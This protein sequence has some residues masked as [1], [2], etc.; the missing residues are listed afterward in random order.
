MAIVTPADEAVARAATQ[1]LAVAGSDQLVT[2]S[3]IVRWRLAGVFDLDE[4][5]RRGR[6][7][8]RTYPENAG[9]I[10]AH[11]A[12]ALAEDR[13]LDQAMLSSFAN[14]VQIARPG[15]LVAYEHL[16]RWMSIQLEKSQTKRVKVKVPGAAGDATGARANQ[17]FHAMRNVLSGGELTAQGAST[18]VSHLAGPE[19]EEYLV[20][21]DGDTS[22]LMEL[23]KSLSLSALRQAVKKATQSDLAWAVSSMDSMVEYIVTL[24]EFFD[25]TSSDGAQPIAVVLANLGRTARKSKLSR[26]VASAVA[27]PALLLAA[28]T[29]SGRRQFD[30]GLA[31]CK[32]ELPR[33]KAI[34]A[35]ARD[36][37]PDVRKYLGITG[38]AAFEVQSE[39]VRERLK[40]LVSAWLDGHPDEKAVL[41]PRQE[42]EGMGE[43][44][45]PQTEAESD[46]LDTAVEEKIVDSP[47]EAERLARSRS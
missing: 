25:L 13:N 16:F 44:E 30:E 22:H 5:G 24:S 15:L 33:L 45:V 1:L 26:G 31:A 9:E 3:Q 27:A 34:V 46:V 43:D 17:L 32:N 2:G 4:P 18:L 36:M 14:G 47:P 39:E 23:L 8:T 6:G 20:A 38:G 12:Q 7:N 41:V 21:R 37:P 19:G 40:G 11:F 29:A 10:A 28:N 42:S 35:L